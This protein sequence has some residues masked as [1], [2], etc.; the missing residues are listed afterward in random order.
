MARTALLNVMVQ[1]VRKAGRS[2][3]RDFGEVENLQVSRKGP[4]D[5]VS[6]ADKK[7]EQI[8]FEEL[9]RVRPGYGF[10]MEES[11]SVEGTDKDN[12]W[13]IDPLDGTTNFLHG[14]PHF[15]ISLALER[16]GHLAAAVVFNPVTD[17]LFTAERGTGAFLNDRRL[18]VAS[19]SALPDTVIGTGIPFIGR[20]DHGLTLKELAAVM[21]QVA[22]IR[23]YGSAALD[24]AWVAAGR[25]DGFWEHDLQPWDM[26]AGLLL[27]QEAGGFAT[28]FDDRD[29]MLKTGGVVAGNAK[30]HQALLAALKLAR[31]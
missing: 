7:A 10:L 29:K 28:D 8:L 16:N 5:F 9:S 26:A 23:R 30:I 1:A 4:G 3:V 15:S 21:P 14:Q 11:G 17:E 31:A 19:R 6:A 25:F 13:I 22:G 27:I 18:R 2:L 24:L 12:L 20:G